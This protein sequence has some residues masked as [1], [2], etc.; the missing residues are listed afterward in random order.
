MVVP[1]CLRV[2]HLK[3]EWCSL[4]VDH[5][6]SKYRVSA[7]TEWSTKQHLNNWFLAGIYKA[8]ARVPWRPYFSGLI[9]C[10]MA[11]CV[12]EI[13]RSCSSYSCSIVFWPS[14]SSYS[15]FHVSA[16]IKSV[17]RFLRLSFQL[18]QRQLRQRLVIRMPPS[19]SV[20]PLKLLQN[21]NDSLG[22]SRASL[23]ICK[24]YEKGILCEF[25]W[26]WT[27]RQEDRPQ[28]ITSGD[29][30]QVEWWRRNIQTC[31]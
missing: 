6:P 19:V 25:E 5:M 28:Y 20:V 7:S 18:I 22:Q 30:R 12:S 3:A 1:H 13:H 2:L 24:L 8:Q 10:K 16:R 21:L 15:S 9:A 4:Q 11:S 31:I 26:Q 23:S 14:L 17:S 29:R 27:G